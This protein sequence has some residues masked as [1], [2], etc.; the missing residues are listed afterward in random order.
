MSKSTRI[1]HLE[2]HLHK[3]GPKI[4]HQQPVIFLTIPPKLS[5]QIWKLIAIGRR[6]WFFAKLLLLGSQPESRSVGEL[7]T[8]QKWTC[9]KIDRTY[10]KL[11]WQTWR[12]QSPVKGRFIENRRLICINDLKAVNLRQMIAT[13]TYLTYRWP[14]SCSIG[15][16][17]CMIDIPNKIFEESNRQSN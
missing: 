10:I 13:H 8:L 14:D 7:S 12:V 4:R 6:T 17:T 1:M 15:Q 5:A 9:I 11:M 16:W 2:V 3:G